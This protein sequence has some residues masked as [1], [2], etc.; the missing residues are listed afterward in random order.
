MATRCEILRLFYSNIPSHS[1]LFY[2]ARV[3]ERNTLCIA[4]TGTATDTR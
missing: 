1:I 3:Q 2:F 4:G